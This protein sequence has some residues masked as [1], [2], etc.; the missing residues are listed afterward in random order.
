[1]EWT[2]PALPYLHKAPVTSNASEYYKYT[3][4]K[5]PSS[6]LPKLSNIAVFL[7]GNVIQTEEMSITEKSWIS[8]LAPLGALVGALPA[9]YVAN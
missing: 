8:F 2:S 1:M 6:A 5:S 9:G 4:I 3:G 7:G